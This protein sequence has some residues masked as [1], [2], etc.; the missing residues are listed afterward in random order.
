M[1]SLLQRVIAL[2]YIHMHYNANAIRE[3]EVGT[4]ESQFNQLNLQWCP[5][6]PRLNSRF[7]KNQGLFYIR[8]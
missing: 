6:S 7:N 4:L 2:N 8:V 1:P 5:D 3:I